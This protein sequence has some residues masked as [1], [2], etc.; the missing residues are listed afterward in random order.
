MP[1]HPAETSVFPADLLEEPPLGPS[2]RSWQVIYTKARQ[3]KALARE[4]VKLEVPF[5]LP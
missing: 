5:F 1:I 3:E 4:L 2:Q